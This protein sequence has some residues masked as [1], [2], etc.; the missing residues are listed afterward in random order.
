MKD[1]P[2]YMVVCKEHWQS[3]ATEALSQKIDHKVEHLFSKQ[4]DM[5]QRVSRFDD[6]TAFKE[7]L[8][9]IDGYIIETIEEDH[10]RT[11]V[12]NAING[13][14]RIFNNHPYFYGL[15]ELPPEVMSNAAN[16]DRLTLGDLKNVM[17][18]AR[19][20][21]AKFIK[22]NIP[23]AT[24][25]FTDQDA[26]ELFNTEVKYPHKTP[27]DFRDFA[28]KYM[29]KKSYSYD[30][31]NTLG[32][33]SSVIRFVND[34][35]HAYNSLLHACKVEV[36]Q[37]FNAHPYF[38]TMPKRQL[39]RPE[40]DTCDQ[41]VSD[42]STVQRETNDFINDQLPPLPAQ[43][44]NDADATR[45]FYTMVRYPRKVPENPAAFL[46]AYLV[47]KKLVCLKRVAPSSWDDTVE[48]IKH[49]KH[50]FRTQRC[51][52]CPVGHRLFSLQG[53]NSHMN[54]VHAVQ[55][56]NCL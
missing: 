47:S 42:F 16:N 40:N 29:H 22:Q 24:E 20:Q 12:K 23:D 53:L 41:L 52:H 18:D 26:I 34:P 33:W 6:F 37:M 31:D 11:Y 44:G 5:I 32:T 35:S 45:L 15:C 9:T 17:K 10:K 28:N 21:A 56:G 55:H 14:M 39:T 25:H 36:E 51:P 2:D 7:Y 54:S 19:I 49:V 46:E 4:V 43:L 50:H 48:Y 3:K 13:I 27:T 30:Y 8:T 38:L 1:N